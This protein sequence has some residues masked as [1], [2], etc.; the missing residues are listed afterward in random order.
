MEGNSRKM[1]IAGQINKLCKRL[2]ISVIALAVIAIAS[3]A[4]IQDLAKKVAK[5]KRY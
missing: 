1:L 3:F 2:L 5:P 4:F